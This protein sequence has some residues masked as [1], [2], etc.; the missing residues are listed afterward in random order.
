MAVL[1]KT[2]PKEVF[3]FFEEISKIPRG[4]YNTK[5]VSD[6]CVDFANERNLEVIQDDLNNIIIK[7]QGTAGYEDSEPVIIQGHLDM[8]CEK[9]ADSTHDFLK[10]PLELYIEDGCVTAKDTTL[11]ADDGIAVAIAL[12]ILDSDSIEHPPIEAVFT[13][14]EEVGMDGAE[15]I[16]LSVLKGKMLLN[17]DS[18]DDKVLTAGCAGGFRFGAELPVQRATVSGKGLEIEICGLKGGHSGMEIN[19]QRGNANKLAGRLLYHLSAGAEVSLVE[20][21]GGAK[22]NVIPSIN[23][24]VIVVQDA[25]AMK[26]SIAEMRD[27]WKQ[28]FGADEPD[29]DVRVTE[30]EEKEYPAMTQESTKKVIFLLMNCPNGVYEYNRSLKGL[31]ETSDNLGVVQTT[32]SS[33][34]IK[35]LTRSGTASKMKEMKERFICLSDYLGASFTFDSEYPAWSFQEQSRIR[36]IVADAFEKVYGTRP[37]VDII[38]AGL[39]CGILCGKKPDLDCVSFGPNMHDIHSVN[40]RLEIESTAKVWEVMKEILKQCK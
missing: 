10:D 32:E 37:K 39:E 15:G 3:H 13:V 19:Q 40:E 26:A 33:L 36:P 30:L 11:G 9:T 21:N 20:T 25:E 29:L 34:V 8:V 38:H 7:K 27:T 5:A 23:K 1:S 2:E 31:V 18:D 17:L 16:D 14:D 24:S 4:T 6:Y 22:D 12:A 28:E 35:T